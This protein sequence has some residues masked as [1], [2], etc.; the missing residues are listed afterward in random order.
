LRPA[1][2]A[3]PSAP[4]A[5]RWPV[6]AGF[7]ARLPLR[8]EARVPAGHRALLQRGGW[9][10]RHRH[11]PV[12]GGR[13]AKAAAGAVAREGLATPGHRAVL[14]G[15]PQAA[16]STARVRRAPRRRRA[17]HRGGQ[18]SVAGR[19]DARERGARP[20]RRRRRGLA[21]TI[22]VAICWASGEAAGRPE[23][24]AGA[25]RVGGWRRGCAEHGAVDDAQRVLH[26]RAGWIARP[27]PGD[28]VGCQP[29]EHLQL[30]QEHSLRPAGGIRRQR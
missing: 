16:A 12:D 14:H 29:A 24:S 27:R 7:R 22:Y 19:P 13:R 28:C 11:S 18:K 4:A 30:V 9:P 15:Q 1:A 26:D 20:R 10:V 21:A 3:G 25:A 5:P 23:G 2:P 17:R 8:A 6:R